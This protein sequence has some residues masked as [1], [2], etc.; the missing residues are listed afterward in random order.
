MGR[1]NIG[2]SVACKTIGT[3]LSPKMRQQFTMK[4]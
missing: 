2:S 3:F 4:R 1:K